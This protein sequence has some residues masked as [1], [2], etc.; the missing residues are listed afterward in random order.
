[1]CQLHVPHYEMGSKGK[2]QVA[3]KVFCSNTHK[4]FAS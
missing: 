4:L 2:S 3:H 1:M